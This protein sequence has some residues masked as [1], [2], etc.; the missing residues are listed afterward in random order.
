MR[1]EPHSGQW[2]RVE[3]QKKKGNKKVSL[4]EVQCGVSESQQ[5]EKGMCIG[6]LSLMS[7]IGAKKGC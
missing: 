5:S 4:E 3:L 1:E 7:A 2:H 6:G